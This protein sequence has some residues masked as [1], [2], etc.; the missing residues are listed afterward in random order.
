[1]I[2]A[3][4][5]YLVFIRRCTRVAFVGDWRYYTWMAVLTIVCLFGLNAYAKQLVHG[6]AVTGMTDEVSW[7][8][9]ISNFTFLV[10]VAAAAV[11]L[12]IPVYIYNNEEMHDLVIFG[13]L[14]AV[15][16]II[17][18]LAFVTVDLGRPD[19]FWHLIPGIGELNFP[20]SMLSWDVLV[21]N[22]YLLLNVH[23]CGYLL[24]CRYRSQKPSKW[25]YIPFV[26]IAIVWAVSIHTV[27][28][29]LYVGLGGRPFWNS[30]IVGPRFLASAFSAGPAIII[31][32]LQ[33]IRRV[34]ASSTKVDF[35]R[36]YKGDAPGRA[37]TMA[38]LDIL[39]AHLPGLNSLPQRDREGLLAHAVVISVSPGDLLL[40]QGERDNSV[41]FVLH[42]RVT[43]KREE[44]GRYRV[45]RNAGPGG[46]FG[47]LSGL[48]NAPRLASAIVEEAGTVLRMPGDTF[49]CLLEF[50]QV[51]QTLRYRMNTRLMITDKALLTLRSILQVSMIIN[52]FL[53]ANEVFKEFYTGNLHVAS[54]QYLFLGLHGHNALVPWIWTA[55]GFN[56]IALV[57]LV[58]PLSRSLKWLDVACVLCII[59]IWIEKGMGLVIPGFI[60]TPLGAIVEYSPTWNETLVSLGIWAFGLLLYTLFLRMAVPILQGRMLKSNEHDIAPQGDETD[61]TVATPVA[62]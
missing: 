51:E 15:A 61:A 20:A 26:F 44:N 60:P 21:L 16:A 23:I 32:A 9:Y 45:T 54:A 8:V 62:R 41:F 31:L 39:G 27:T 22:G 13:E 36:P 5:D 58:L 38:D 52:V 2:T 25:F 59:G 42:G 37:A 3:T 30:A 49:R 40:R 43:V 19:R 6:L 50:Q 1:M 12:V 11:M 24:Y 55:I 29:F 7:G 33:I 48:T 53:L 4:R 17:M 47:E 35:T 14:L 28:A 18:C 46:Q 56:L 34:T 10:G 57:I